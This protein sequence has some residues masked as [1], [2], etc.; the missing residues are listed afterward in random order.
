MNILA[1]IGSPRKQSN[2]DI[3]V[4][5]LLEGARQN[6]HTGEK[7][8]LY[9]YQISGCIDCR[10]CKEKDYVCCLQDDMQKI[11]PKMQNAD[12]LIFGTPIYWYGPTAKMKLLIDRMRP[13]IASK[14]LQG[15]KAVLVVPSE[16]GPTACKALLQMFRLSLNY[17]GMQL[18]GKLLATAYQRAEIAN[19]KKELNKAYRLGITL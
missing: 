3:L 1:L 11:Y 6:R 12:L 15:K 8:Y 9:D 19:N 4:D 10:S 5:K 17:L 14:K 13:F 7:I 2:T 16:E 18:A